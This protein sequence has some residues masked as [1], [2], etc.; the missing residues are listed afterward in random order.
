MTDILTRSYDRMAEIIFELGDNSKYIESDQSEYD[1][2]IKLGKQMHLYTEYKSLVEKV[3]YITS[4]IPKIGDPNETTFLEYAF[5][6]GKPHMC[7]RRI[8][9]R[10]LAVIEPDLF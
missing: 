3:K 9:V 7:R 1:I 6:D 4:D 5:K 8:P 10:R 2:S